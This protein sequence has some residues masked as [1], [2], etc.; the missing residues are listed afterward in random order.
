[1]MH[2]VGDALYYGAFKLSYIL[3]L[4]HYALR[5][6]KVYCGSSSSQG[7]LN[8]IMACGVLS[9]SSLSLS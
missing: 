3:P 7:I 1:M 2:F 4:T 9:I 5:L 6:S 8:S